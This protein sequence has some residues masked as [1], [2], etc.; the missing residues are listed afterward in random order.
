MTFKE[1]IRK[2]TG[3]FLTSSQELFEKIFAQA[4]RELKIKKKPKATAQKPVTAL[5]PVSRRTDVKEPEAATSSGKTVP[6]YKTSE[7]VKANIQP[8]PKAKPISRKG[9][10]VLR[11]GLLFILLLVLAGFAAN[12][13]DIID[14]SI[15]PDLLGLGPKP[16]VQAP[17]PRKQPAK[18]SEK[19]ASAPKQA[20]ESVPPTAP[21]PSVPTPPALSKEEKLVE[22]ETPTTIAQSP[23]VKER[24]EEKAPP[25]ASQA[26]PSPPEGAVK[27]E[28]QP[29]PVPTQIPE[30][31][32]APKAASSK[33]SVPQYPYSVYLGSF[34]APEAVKKAL[35][36]Y[37][38]KGLSAYWVKVDLGDKGVWYRFFTGY[39]RSKL[40][41]EKYI[42]DHNIQGAEPGITKYAN[43]IGSYGSDKEV[44]V[45]QRA[46][47]S[48][49]FYPYVIKD[50]DGKSLV[51]SGAFDRKEYAEKE[52][53]DL[54]SKGIMS[55]V[56]ER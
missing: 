10:R 11:T 8:K 39:F 21:A 26:Q 37:Q 43:L 55:T 56:V 53:N 31:P 6:T 41:A 54:A 34:K 33:P 5:S 49:G 48:A 27:G 35:S 42:K 51:Y 38:E 17:I 47:L 25:V 29:V 18:P 44:E 12:H 16:I 52:R 3:A 23:S 45:Q 2:K 4:T 1:D 19:T 14:L 46:I 13:F 50:A 20:Q 7:K 15:V 24:I 32:S 9:S 28:P 30:K 40:E 36:D 22:L